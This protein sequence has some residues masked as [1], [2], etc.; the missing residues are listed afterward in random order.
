VPG[1]GADFWALV[2]RYPRTERARGF[3]EGYAAA[4]GEAASD[5]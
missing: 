4:S 3:L 2:A 1:H 5:D